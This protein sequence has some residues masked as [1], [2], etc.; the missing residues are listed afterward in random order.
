MNKDQRRDPRFSLREN[1]TIEA[2]LHSPCGDNEWGA[3]V[4]DISRRGAK[5]EVDG[6]MPAEGDTKFRLKCDKLNWDIEV[7]G[8]IH[9]KH[10]NRDGWWVGC[11]FSTAVETVALERLATAGVIDR[12]CENRQTVNRNVDVK[13]ELNEGQARARLVDVSPGG[14]KLWLPHSVNTGERVIL[15][16][17]AGADDGFQSVGRTCW[18]KSTGDGFFAGCSFVQRDGF[19]N[20]LEALGLHEEM[21]PVKR[22]RVAPIS[23]SSKAF[24]WPP[25]SPPWPSGCTACSFTNGEAL[26][27]TRCRE[28]LIRAI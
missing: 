16:H 24:H 8:K 26:H 15:A 11:S 12:R 21:A 19:V 9:W 22:Q 20:L 4:I 18:V 27:A 7:P 3:R 5:L 6:A 1:E 2:R 17:F 14:F 23:L 10:P 25:A 28:R 13:L